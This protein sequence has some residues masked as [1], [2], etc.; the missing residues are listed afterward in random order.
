MKRKRII[1]SLAEARAAM[2]SALRL[3]LKRIGWPGCR[4]QQIE[5]E[6]SNYE[7]G[8]SDALILAVEAEDG[9]QTS[10]RLELRLCEDNIEKI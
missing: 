8:L 4:D 7:T 6:L 5:S 1:V 10:T 3:K 2:A 9:A